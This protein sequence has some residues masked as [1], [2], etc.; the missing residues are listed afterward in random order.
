[1]G[2]ST[3]ILHTVSRISVK[4]SAF[5]LEDISIT[6]TGFW[7]QTKNNNIVF[8]TNKHMVDPKLKLS[9]ETPYRIS[10]L[11]L[12]MR[13]Y[14][15][16]SSKYLA[17]VDQIDIPLD[18]CHLTGSF[19]SD[20]SILEFKGKIIDDSKYGFAHINEN[21]LATSEDFLNNIDV[22]NLLSFVGFPKK[23]TDKQFDLPI[24]RNSYIASHPAISYSHNEIKTIDNCLVSGMSFSG[25]S[26]SPVFLHKT[27]K[28][29]AKV[30]GLMSG[31]WNEG[32]SF[33]HSGL[34]FFTKSTAI[35]SLLQHIRFTNSGF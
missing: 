15:Y 3:Q 31:H 17:T 34:S 20:C 33:V 1:M 30:V 12:H 10:S 16:I 11:K 28:S 2:L 8:V 14:D 26:G 24:S 25:S 21:M 35:I 6:G 32:D 23:W 27:S 18:K 22:T 19:Y 9:S 13:H 4:F 29:E 7:L 5:G